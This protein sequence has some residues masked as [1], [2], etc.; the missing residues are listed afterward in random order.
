MVLERR[1]IASEASGANAGALW[2]QGELSTPSPY[3]KLAL[4]SFDRF[5]GLAVELRDL[6][7]M[8]I[9]FQPSGL[10]TIIEECQHVEEIREALGWRLEMGLAFKLMDW[11]EVHHFEP[12]LAEH[13][14][15]G[16]YFPHEGDVNPMYLNN[17][18]AVG[19]QRLGAKYLAGAEVTGISLS[20]GRVVGVQT[21][22]GPVAADAV[23]IAAGAWSPALGR[24]A[25][26]CI[27]VRPVRGQIMVTEQLPPLF[28]HCLVA[29]HTYL[30]RKA[31][32]GIVIG[33]TQEEVGYRKEMT[34]DGL[35]GLAAD[36]AS[37]VPALASVSIV[38][39]WCGLRPGSADDW[40][41]LGSVP[42]IENLILAT[43]HFRNGCLLSP[44]T[45]QVI[46]ELIVDGHPSVPLHPFRLDRFPDWAL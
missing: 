30:V 14:A 29:G 3:L 39:S 45:G 44:A 38:R 19:A 7:G 43:G 6:T 27:P 33:A 32:G 35:A 10:L 23:V 5:P 42:G 8:D 28:T 36:A 16:L 4:L 34:V 24:M 46:S 1:G 15:G 9:E 11:E 2:P 41:F 18:Y 31:T 17:A 13:I 12:A 21:G 20:A 25:G 26:L 22:A 40:P 37:V